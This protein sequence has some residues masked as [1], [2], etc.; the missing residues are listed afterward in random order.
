MTARRPFARL[1][2]AAMLLAA[3][4]LPQ[5]HAQGYPAKPIRFVV[6]FAPGSSTDIVARLVAEQVRTKLGQPVLVDNEPGANGMLG[7]AEVAKSAPDGY[8][9]LIPHVPY[10]GA[11][12]A[13]QA[14]LAREV[15]A[16]FDTPSGVPH[17]KAGRLLGLA[18]SSAQRWRDLP[19]VPTMAES[20]FP[21]FDLTFWVGA[22]VP[23]GTPQP[24]MD[25]LTDAIRAAADDPETRKKL[26]SQGSLQMLAP[27]AFQARVKAETA[28]WGEIIRRRGISLDQ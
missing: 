15:D 24:V 11:A 26:E 22:L 21:G 1:A 8:T 2:A 12:P 5:A 25:K 3:G 19:E 13:Q 9:V 28:M 7:A 14:V 6:G 20:G 27:A 16:A 17:I 23:A 18:V 4:G 10:K